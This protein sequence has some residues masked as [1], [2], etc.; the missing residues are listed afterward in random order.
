MKI[1]LC[2]DNAGYELKSMIEGYLESQG[3]EFE[4]FGTHSAESM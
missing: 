1:A 3:K 2:S 4:D